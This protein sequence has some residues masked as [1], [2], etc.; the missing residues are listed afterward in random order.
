MEWLDGLEQW[1]VVREIESIS[2]HNALVNLKVADIM[3]PP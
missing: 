1:R 3:L 2:M